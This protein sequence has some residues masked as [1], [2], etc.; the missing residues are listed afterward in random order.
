LCNEN[1]QTNRNHVAAPRRYCTQEHRILLKRNNGARAGIA[2]MS[3]SLFIKPT[4]VAAALAAHY[5]PAAA[6]GS[7]G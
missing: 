4:A 6:G 1:L 2:A 5:G 3:R 7:L